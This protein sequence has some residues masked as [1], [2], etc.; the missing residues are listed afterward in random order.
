VRL[1]VGDQS[2]RLPARQPGRDRGRSTLRQLTAA[3]PAATP[4][5]LNGERPGSPQPRGG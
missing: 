5:P 2:P 1:G 4:A 3:R